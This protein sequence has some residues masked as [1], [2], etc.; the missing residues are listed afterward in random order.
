MNTHT[1]T[2]PLGGTLLQR[3]YQ[4]WT[5]PTRNTRADALH[6]A[7]AEAAS[8][9]ALADTYRNSDPSFA[10]DLYAAA[11]RHEQEAERAALRG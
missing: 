7:A 11:D 8:V 10:S 5:L 1:T 9:R 3:W 6:S 2:L 4:R